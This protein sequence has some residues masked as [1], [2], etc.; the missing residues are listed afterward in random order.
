M[1]TGTNLVIERA[2]YWN[3]EERKKGLLV[4]IHFGPP[5]YKQE[6]ITRLSMNK[7]NAFSFL[8][9]V[10]FRAMNAGKML[11]HDAILEGVE[12]DCLS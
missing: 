11:R 2:V 5:K 12:Y 3:I 1:T 8:T 10:F 6:A 4:S 7:P 9:F